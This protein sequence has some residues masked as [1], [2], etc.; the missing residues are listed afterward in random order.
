MKEKIVFSLDIG[1]KYT[2]YALLKVNGNNDINI[3]DYG[4]ILFDAS[5]PEELYVY[6]S[7]K[8]LK[9]FV[10]EKISLF[11]D[12][13]VIVLVEHQ[14]SDF[15]EKNMRFKNTKKKQKNLN[16][17]K[18]ISL[19]VQNFLFDEGIDFAYIEAYKQNGNGWIQ[20]LSN[21]YYPNNTNLYENLLQILE[22]PKVNFCPSTKKEEMVN[23]LKDYIE[24]WKKTHKNISSI[25]NYLDAIAM[26]L[27]FVLHTNY[28][29]SS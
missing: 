11:P 13:E 18:E 8:T 16:I 20:I 24:V 29:K 12:N 9:K 1:S 23:K 25:V 4:T 26:S 27:V 3:F 5:I 7:A 28:I 17:T 10:K 15:F 6:E 19:L 14:K 22:T 21:S 2:G